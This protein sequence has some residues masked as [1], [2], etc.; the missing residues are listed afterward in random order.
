[1][2]WEKFITFNVDIRKEEWLKVS[3]LNVQL[4]FKIVQK[5][6]FQRKKKERRP[7]INKIDN[8]EK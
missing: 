4:K 1:M 2:L 6:K 3:A 7:E 5:N 8:K